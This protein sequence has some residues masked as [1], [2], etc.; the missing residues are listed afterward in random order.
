[1][2]AGNL[3]RIITIERQTTDLDLYGTPIKVW[4]PVATMRAHKLENA[5]SDQGPRGKATDATITF[6]TRWLDGIGLENR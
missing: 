6:R 3:D 4:V 2:R 1:M 5:I